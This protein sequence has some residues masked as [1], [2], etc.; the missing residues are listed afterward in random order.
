MLLNDKVALRDLRERI[1]AALLD[2]AVRCELTSLKTGN[3]SFDADG[4]GARIQVKAVAKRPD[5]KTREQLDFEK[6][7]AVFDLKPEHLGAKFTRNGSHFEVIGLM[8][9]R[10]KYPIVAKNTLTGKRLLF[11]TDVVPRLK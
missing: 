6:Y 1:D 2:I 5:G 3:I 10:R 4:V 8:P 7:H 9:N 11:T